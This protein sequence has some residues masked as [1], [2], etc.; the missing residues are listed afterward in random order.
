[1]S[2]HSINLK[3]EVID[4]YLSGKDGY[5]LT[6][7]RFGVQKGDVRFWVAAYQAHGAASLIKPHVYYTSEFKVSVVEH[8]QQHGLSFL[9]TAAY[10]NIP[11]PSMILQWQ[12]LYNAGNITA[13][14]R[15]RG[16]QPAMDKPNSAPTP[17]IIKPADT[18][19][20]EELLDE[21]EYLRVENLYLKKLDALIR[22]KQQAATALKKKRK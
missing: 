6:A 19:T 9:A 10:F 7:E 1:M 12:R 14:A 11:A 17:C 4:H 21:L 16:R 13:L 18:R 2:K 8:L 5:G 22:A 20:R 3:L 15:N